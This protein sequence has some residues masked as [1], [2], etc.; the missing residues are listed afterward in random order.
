MPKNAA[1]TM[2]YDGTIWRIL[3]YYDGSYSNSWI[4]K[5]TGTSITSPIC[6][7][8]V[9][10]GFN[11]YLV[12]PNP[13]TAPQIITVIHNGITRSN[14]AVIFPGESTLDNNTGG[15][16]AIRPINGNWNAGIRFITDKT[17]WYILD[18]FNAPE[19]WYSMTTGGPLTTSRTMD[20]AKNIIYI[21]SYDSGT[22]SNNMTSIN[23]TNLPPN[24]TGIF[25]IKDIQNTKYAHSIVLKSSTPMFGTGDRLL[26]YNNTPK[27]MSGLIIASINNGSTTNHYVVGSYLG[28]D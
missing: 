8:N 6:I 5:S 2:T 15:G 1:I 12:L 10:S 3:S 11:K 24:K 21:S 4:T 23:L 20:P 16:V 22:T 14:D 25:Y 18:F 28:Y 27:K 26:A 19:T 7:A 17:K 9:I 13:S